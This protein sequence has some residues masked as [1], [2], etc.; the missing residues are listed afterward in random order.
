MKTLELRPVYVEFVP[1]DPTEGVLYISEEYQTAIHKCPCGCGSEVVT[2]LSGEH[3]WQLTGSADAVTL[4]PS[5]GNWNCLCQSHY[6]VT[7]NKVEWL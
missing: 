5:V 3:A 1:D 6:Y 7:A 2:P 4:R